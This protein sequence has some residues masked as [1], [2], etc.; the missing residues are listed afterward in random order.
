MVVNVGK[1][2]YFA[3]K[4]LDGVIDISP[5]TCMNGIVAKQSIPA[6]AATTPASPSAISILTAPIPTWTAT[7][8]SSGTCPLLSAPQT[9]APGNARDRQ[10]RDP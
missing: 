4:G 10:S 7:S 5:F 3:H 1:A 8:A 6:S 9:L 2:V